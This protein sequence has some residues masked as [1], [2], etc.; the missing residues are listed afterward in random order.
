VRDAG[1][2][3][4]EITL[5]SR[6]A[7]EAIA[8]FRRHFGDTMLIGAGT[9]RVIEQVNAA[10]DADA[11]FIVSPNFDA[12]SVALS[13]ERDI[14]HL[15]GVFTPTEAETA[16]RAGCRLLKL[17]PADAMGPAYL[18]ALRAPLNDIEFIPTGGVSVANLAQYVKAGAVAV[19]IGSAL[20]S[21][22]QQSVAEVAQRA[23][24]LRTAWDA[25]HA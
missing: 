24:A 1:I 25:A 16:F 23:A 20:I 10:L 8:A 5:N 12:A 3:V 7:L 11:Q 6:G 18:K 19:G 9:V 14:L 22:P 15:P 21:G 2:S 17:F 13:Q 4:L